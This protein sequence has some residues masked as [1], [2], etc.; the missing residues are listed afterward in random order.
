VDLDRRSIQHR[1]QPRRRLVAIVAAMIAGTAT[2]VGA[3]VAHAAA[4]EI[5]RSF[6]AQSPPCSVGVGVAFDGFQLLVSCSNTNVLSGVSTVDGAHIRDYPIQGVGGIGAISFD[7]AGN[8]V[9]LCEGSSDRVYTADLFS[10]VSKLMFQSSGCFDGLAYDSTDDTVWASP[11]ASTPVTHYKTD[12]TVLG[13][14]DVSGKLGSCGNSGIAAGASE[15]FLSNNGCSEIYRMAKDGTGSTRVGTYPARLEDLECDDVTFPGTSVIWSKDAYDPVLNAFDVGA[16]DCG[17]N[18]YRDSDAD[19]IS[20]TWESQGADTDGNGTIDVDLPAMGANP[21]RK[22]LFV[23]ADWLTKQPRKI[24]PISLGGGYAHTPSPDALSRVTSAFRSW[25]VPNPDGSQG[26]N[27]HIDGGPNTVMNPVT[28]AK[29]GNRSRANGIGNALEPIQWPNDTYWSR[30]DPIREDN[31]DEARRGLFHYLLYVDSLGCDSS[32]CTTGISRGIP[33]HDLLLARGKID[34]DLQEAVTLAH[35]L[36]HNLG[37][38]HGGRE[39]SDEPGSRHVNNKAN[40]LSIMNYFYS[41]T[42]LRTNGGYDGIIAYSSREHQPLVRDDLDETRGLEPDPFGHFQASYRCP[43][44]TVKRADSWASI[45]WNCDGTI[46]NGSTNGQL[47]DPAQVAAF[48]ANPLHVLGSEDYH[49][50]YFW[51]TGA[52]WDA[53]N[54]NLIDR[55]QPGT[56]EP[57]VEQAKADG[58]WYPDLTVQTTAN[59]AV[60]AYPNTDTVD[61]PLS[62]ANPGSTPF[63][64]DTRLVDADP[65]FTLPAGT[66]LTMQT[67]TTQTLHIA[68]ATASATAGQEFHATIRYGQAQFGDLGSIDLVVRIPGADDLGPGACDAARQARAAADLPTHQAPALDAYI[69]RCTQQTVTIDIKPGDSTNTINIKSRGKTPVAILGSAAFAPAIVLN[70]QSVTFGRTGAETSLSGCTGNGEDVNG[71][72][73]RDL[74]CHFNTQQL[75]LHVGDVEAILRGKT[76][77][78]V[79]FESRGPVRV[80]S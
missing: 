61:I 22:D 1:R 4:G 55:H 54:R 16:I 7:R 75:G 70:R 41:N 36:G 23:E 31:V 43:N 3:P 29:W 76:N 24:G 37:L 60:T 74:V 71:D 77:A 47:Q 13:T 6:D 53:R 11:D 79:A 34:S 52:A 59:V 8:R 45:D 33:G 35:E 17:L 32:G 57:T 68:F 30:L 10:G 50:L 28:G 12:G 44:K 2:I 66:T 64:L 15:L 18:A 49:H 48:D 39:R 9:W 78:G 40:Y 56:V 14:I 25:P 65:R 69:A 80:I 26:V 20:D 58:L 42:G 63:T 46:A 72:G 21:L 73:Y 38:G 27:L 62:L 19:G 67:G 5:V 51:G